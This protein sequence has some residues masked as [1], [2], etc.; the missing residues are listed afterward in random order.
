MTEPPPY[1]GTYKQKHLGHTNPFL[2]SEERFYR[3]NYHATM[4]TISH[5]YIHSLKSVGMPDEERTL[6]LHLNIN[7]EEPVSFIKQKIEKEWNHPVSRQKLYF[8]RADGTRIMDDHQLT[9]SYGVTM[10]T[11]LTLKVP[12][13]PLSYEERRKKEEK[14]IR[15][16]RL[17]Y[18]HH[19]KIEYVREGNGSVTCMKNA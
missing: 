19:K 9:G 13:I 4:L 12:P 8:Q 1:S 11:T 6:E 2:N 18:A 5:T 16:K 17:K 10:G 15:D 7:L 14:E 3:P